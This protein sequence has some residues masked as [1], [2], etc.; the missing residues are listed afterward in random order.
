MGAQAMFWG[1]PLLIVLHKQ[2]DSCSSLLTVLYPVLCM[3]RS[4]QYVT[5]NV[6]ARLSME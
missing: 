2:Q 5:P 6:A 3:L 1:T 4:S